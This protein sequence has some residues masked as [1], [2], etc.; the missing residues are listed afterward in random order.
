MRA[1]EQRVSDTDEGFTLIELLVVMIIIAVLAAIAIPV[2]LNQRSKADDATAKGDLRNLANFEEIYLNDYGTYSS[3]ANV[4]LDEPN[5]F[6]S[7]N[8]TLTVVDYDG[9][10]G[11]CLSAMNSSNSHT[12][13]YD[14]EG[15][16]LQPYG[17]TGCPDVTTGLPGG[18]VSN[19]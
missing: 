18:S 11:Y 8:I 10:S 15:G 19:P 3:I 7:K 9:V 14:S 4:R 2:F 6:P 17:S 12:W 13:Y 5:I 1:L 16:G